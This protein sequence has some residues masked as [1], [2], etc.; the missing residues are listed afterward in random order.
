MTRLEHEPSYYVASANQNLNYPTLEEENSCDVCVIGGGITGASAALHLRQKGYEV[1]LLESNRVAWGASGRSGGQYIFGYSCSQKVLEKNVGKADAKKLWDLS[2]DSIRLV[3]QLIEEHQIECDQVAGQISVAL[4]PRQ[5][6][7]LIEWK[8]ELENDYDY[9]GLQLYEG[10]ELKSLLNSERY[11]AGLFDPQS[12]H[13][14]PMN[15]TLGLMRAAEKAGTMIFEGSKATKIEYSDN[16]VVYTEKGSVKCKYV[17]LAGN[18]YLGDLAEKLEKRI[19][20]VGT[21]IGASEVLGKE[22][23]KSLISNNM[24]VCDI[25]FVLDYYRLSK[26][27][28][29]LF[30]GRVSYS[31]IDP[32]NLAETMR[33]RMVTVFPQLKEVKM[34]YA[35]GGYV[36]ITM[37]R[38]PHFGRLRNNVYFAQ[39]FSGHGIALTGMAG[40]LMAE[41]LAGTAEKFDLFE[42]I[43][44]N[45][46]PGGKYMRTPGLVLAMAYFRLRDML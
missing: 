39:G 34:D 8:A 32:W 9:K 40:K 15:Y 3:N 29:M 19:M 45:P 18:A 43:S 13:L 28:R 17:I 27:Y 44:H 36:G 42:K 6:R 38:A 2:I 12:G 5:H 1:T 7:E 33:K 37:N 20:P 10:D 30:G 31:K 4:K 16:P 14:H 25:N 24:G 22:R 21:Y 46:F 41:A 11:L 35:W 26:D 23:A